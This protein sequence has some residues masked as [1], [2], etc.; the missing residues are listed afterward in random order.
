MMIAA[1]K[2]IARFTSLADRAIVP[3]LPLNGRIPPIR[4]STPRPNRWRGSWLRWRKMFSTMITVAST[5]S[6]KSIAPID[7]RLADSP[8]AT[9]IMTANARAK[10]MVI[11]TITADR[12]LPRKIHC[13]AKISR[14]PLAMFSST[15]SIV[16]P[17]SSVRS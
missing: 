16:T 3:S 5:I 12:Q 9:M 14:I 15:V 1:A 2:K 8:R 17:I 6:P 13:T 10:G 11:A 4:S 7:S